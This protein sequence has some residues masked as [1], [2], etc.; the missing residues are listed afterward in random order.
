VALREGAALACLFVGLAVLL[1]ADLRDEEYKLQQVARALRRPAGA[2]D[3]AQRRPRVWI[4]VVLLLAMGAVVG[5][6]WARA[7]DAVEVNRA[8]EGLNVAVAGLA[9]MLAVIVA[10]TVSV[11]RRFVGRASLVLSPLRES[12]GSIEPARATT[13]GHGYWTAAGLRRFH[14]ATCPALASAR[15]ERRPVSAGNAGLEPCLLCD[16][17]E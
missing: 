17:G 8:L 15:G 7:A 11:R 10:A 13:N 14:R 6:G 5:L 9:G 1:A 2:G 16:A 12:P 4:L 3:R